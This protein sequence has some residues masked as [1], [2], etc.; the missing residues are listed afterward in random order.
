MDIFRE[1][2]QFKDTSFVPNHVKNITNWGDIFLKTFQNLKIWR[3][4]QNMKATSKIEIQNRKIKMKCKIKNE[5]WRR[6][7][8]KHVAHPV[9]SSRV[10][11][12]TYR[13][14]RYWCLKT[15]NFFIRG[16]VKRVVPFMTICLMTRVARSA[17][18]N[19]I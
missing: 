5:N 17:F 18:K 13:F 12:S 19:L 15:I 16:W 6:R 3:K 1:N 11:R 2:A 8:K 10:A 9:F 14:D 7:K 4:F